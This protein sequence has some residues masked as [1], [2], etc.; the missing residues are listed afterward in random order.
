[1]KAVLFPG[2]G[3]QYV[4]MGYDFYN[5]FDLAKKI[6]ETVDKSLGFSLSNIILNGPEDELKL[7]KNTQPAIMTVGVSI[8]N[9]LNKHFGFNLNNT[10]FFAGHSLGEYTALVCAGSLTLEKAAY[11]LHE[12]GKAMQEAVPAGKGLM[13]AILGMSI[14]EVQKEV[15]LVSKKEICEV[16]NDNSNGQVVVSGT[17]NAI[18]TLNENLK[19]KKKKSIILP[20]SA[21]FHCS[22]MKSASE[23]M[24]DKIEN[25]DFF[26]PK[27]SIISNVTAQEENDSSRIKSL[28]IEQITSR[29]RWRESVNYLIKHGVDDFLEIGPGKVLSGLVK[30]I[31]KNVKVANINSLEDVDKKNDKF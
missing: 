23:K 17:K 27:P 3:S 31:N 30:K 20:V 9:V 14:D 8:F 22:M 13:T 15:D 10:K 6:F 21:P 1:M 25:T 16:A 18:E 26:Q 19:I 29:V 7:T 24:R 5:K 12:R 2:Q 4:K 28:L 11:L